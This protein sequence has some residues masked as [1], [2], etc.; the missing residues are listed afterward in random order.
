MNRIKDRIE[1][2]VSLTMLNGFLDNVTSMLDWHNSCKHVFSCCMILV[3]L[4]NCIE[5]SLACNGKENNSSYN[6]SRFISVNIHSTRKCVWHVIFCS[7]YKHHSYHVIVLIT[8]LKM[9]CCWVFGVVK[10][11]MKST[12]NSSIRGHESVSETVPKN[13]V[14]LRKKSARITKCL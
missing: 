14:I 7:F 8:M 1:T 13:V 9:L 11:L 4:L 6:A 10:A 5:T 3:V 12:W 2:Q